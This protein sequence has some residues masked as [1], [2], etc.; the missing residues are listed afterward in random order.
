M[1]VANCTETDI[2][3]LDILTRKI[4]TNFEFCYLWPVA[5]EPT[6]LVHGDNFMK[7]GKD[8]HNINQD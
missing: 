4:T 6:L 3:L 1:N 5:E 2:L 8:F 7:K